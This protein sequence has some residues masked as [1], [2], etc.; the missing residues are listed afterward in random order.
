MSLDVFEKKNFGWCRKLQKSFSCSLDSREFTR[1]FKVHTMPSFSSYF[2]MCRV[3]PVPRVQGTVWFD[4]R[5]HRFWGV[6]H[7]DSE[8]RP[9]RRLE[10]K[11]HC[12]GCG[13]QSRFKYI[14][15]TARRDRHTIAAVPIIRGFLGHVSVFGEVGRSPGVPTPTHSA[16][17]RDRLSST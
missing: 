8:G 16:R 14:L 4:P 13:P 2:D 12:F 1:V 6:H 15:T 11:L 17:F 7:A 5:T 3:S 10:D 9:D